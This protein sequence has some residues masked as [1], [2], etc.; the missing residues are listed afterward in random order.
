VSKAVNIRDRIVELRRVKA[1]DLVSNPKNWRTHPKAQKDALRGLLADVGY[2][3][4]LLAR[5]VPGGKLMLIDGHLRAETT[6]D[7]TVPVL[8]LD[9]T[10]AEGDKILATLDPLAAMAGRDND[11]LRALLAR[12][13]TDDAA[14][15]AM[16]EKLG[17]APRGGR[18]DPDDAVERSANP[19]C[20]LGDLF[21]LGD[22]RLLCG[23]STNPTT[24]KR[25][26]G[27]D[28]PDLMMTDPPYGVSYDPAWRNQAGVGLAPGRSL[29]KV[30]NDDR[31][32]WTD[33]WKL[34]PGDVA[35]V[36]HGGLHSVEVASSLVASGFELRCQIIWAKQH[37][38]LSRGDYHWQHE[39]CWY[40][41]RKGH[42][43]PWLG[44][45]KQ[46]TLWSVQT[47]GG[48]GSSKD[49]ANERTGHGT[50]K[51]VELFRRALANH[52]QDGDACY[53]PFSGSG[54][55]IIAAE[56]LGRRCFAMEIDPGYVRAAVTRWEKFT[57]KTATKA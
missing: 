19:R 18:T 44:D 25:L 54:S 29:G 46:A 15:R 10:E 11:Q 24:V 34:F 8:V 13:E 27:K 37:F 42:K 14:L 50:Q 53:E 3:D 52:T 30:E 5:V 12:I 36:W 43:A 28:K 47:T 23:D 40:A 39:P 48:F 49:A 55:Q 45:R 16:L 4:A 17:K 20:R 57:G 41:H 32:D 33:A 56:Q 2:A 22:H 51:P 21:H 35:Y 9:V 6:P 26:L 38:A 1:S 7:Q 31:A